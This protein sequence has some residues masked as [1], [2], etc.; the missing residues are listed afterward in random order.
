MNY[1]LGK[2]YI[3]EPLVDHPVEDI[4]IGSTCQPR[5][6]M[7]LANHHSKYKRWLLGKTNNVSSFK[8]FDTYGFENCQIVLIESVNCNS[9]DELT[10]REAF[11][12]RNSQCVNKNI[13]LRTNKEYYLDNRNVKLFYRKE[14]Y[15]ENREVI[16]AKS[17]LYEA[18]HKNPC[19]C[20][21]GGRY[22][23][24][25]QKNTHFKTNKHIKYIESHNNIISE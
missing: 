5:L 16:L 22:N 25:S 21:C 12:I 20:V 11:H 10:S 1:S 17:I 18:A 3:I 2:V 15:K 7:R 8:L 9:K 13:P 23:N 19:I 24:N 6:A 4:Y 14:H